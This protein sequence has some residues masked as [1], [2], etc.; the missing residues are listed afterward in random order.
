VS[1]VNESELDIASLPDVEN[2]PELESKLA[3]AT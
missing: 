3:V 2:T 1:D